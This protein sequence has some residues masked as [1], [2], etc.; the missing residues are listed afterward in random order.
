ML[1]YSATGIFTDFLQHFTPSTEFTQ[2]W[3]ESSP[4]GDWN[5]GC[6]HPRRA[7]PLK[8]VLPTFVGTILTP[9]Y[10]ETVIY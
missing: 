9:W 5:R 2:P 8:P 7:S 6:L 10:G 1:L 4:L 3:C